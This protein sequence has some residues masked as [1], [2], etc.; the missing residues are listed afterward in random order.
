MNNVLPNRTVF[1]RLNA[2]HVM[3]WEIFYPIQREWH[4]QAHSAFQYATRARIQQRRL[5]AVRE[6]IKGICGHE[7]K[8]DGFERIPNAQKTHFTW[9]FMLFC[10][11]TIFVNPRKR[12]KLFTNAPALRL[13]DKQA[14]R[15]RGRIKN[16]VLGYKLGYLEGQEP[17][18]TII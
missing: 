8:G 2:T 13:Y 15:I 10:I 18:N 5:K 9:V 16:N 6:Q 17:P 1:E 12:G 7:Q 3:Y 14:N 11:Q 4:S